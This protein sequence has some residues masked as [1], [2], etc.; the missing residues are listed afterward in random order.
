MKMPPLNNISA[1]ISQNH[2][3]LLDIALDTLVLKDDFF[4]K[5][6]ELWIP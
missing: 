2:L 3:V 4:K 6:G 5:G 1:K